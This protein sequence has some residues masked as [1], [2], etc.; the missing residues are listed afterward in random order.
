MSE[1]RPY[2]R[3]QPPYWWAAKPYRA[4]TLRELTGVFVALYALVLL[5]GLVALER[6]PDAFAAY[7]AIMRSPGAVILHLVLLLF[8]L[9]HAVTWFQTLPKTQPKIIIGG[10]IVPPGRVTAV[11]QLA[12]ALCWL[13]LLAAALLLLGRMAP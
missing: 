7:G 11:A 3:P 2:R 1:R 6:G 12:A 8:M 10:R 13:L 4:Y 9:W 5:A